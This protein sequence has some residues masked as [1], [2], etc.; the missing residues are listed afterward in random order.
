[1][2]LIFQKI[3]FDLFKKLNQDSFKNQVFGHF[4]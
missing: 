4:F 3:D 1:L 2:D